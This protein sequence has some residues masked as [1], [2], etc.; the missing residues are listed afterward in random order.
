MTLRHVFSTAAA[1]AL[2]AAGAHAQPADEGGMRQLGAHVHGA[3]E[4]IAAA[5]P[6]G[7]VVAELS[8]AAW[9]LYGFESTA[10]TD[11][12][13]ETVQAVRARLAEPGLIVFT[14][15]AGCTL[16]DTSVSGGPQPGENGH[17]HA[18]HDH[19]GD[20]AHGD[21]GDATDHEGHADHGDHD[22]GDAHDHGEAHD[23]DHAH[24]HG[25][26]HDHE[27]GHDHGDGHDHAHSD[28]VVSWSFQC[29]APERLAG[30]D[31]SGL[32]TAF[33]RLERLEVQYLDAGGAA[34]RQL[35]PADSRLPLD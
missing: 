1:A 8:S 17:D 11:A 6:D 16:T 15:A 34:A 28:V 3:A 5:D 23:H 19:D 33:D 31:L 13:R 20:H 2:C 26:G 32:F 12:Q 21:H 4:L 24:D 7:L 35:T 29:T 25:D 18:H 30:L 9:N 14:D 10:E 22:H 27:A